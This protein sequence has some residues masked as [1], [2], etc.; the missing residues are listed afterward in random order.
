MPKNSDYW[1]DRATSRMENYHRQTEYNKAIRQAYGEAIRNIQRDIDRILRNLSRR[2]G[3]TQEEIESELEKPVDINIIKEYKD[4][5]LSATDDGA[6]KRMQETLNIA[7][8][9]ARM[10]RL[11]AIETAI[12]LELQKAA[13]TQIQADRIVLGKIIDDAYYR[14]MFHIQKGVGYGFSFNPLSKSAANEILR[15]LWSGKSWSSR[16][17]TNTNILADRLPKS[18]MASFL[19]GI[20][21]TDLVREFQEQAKTQIMTQATYFARRLVYTE[22]T[23]VANMTEIESY[24]ECDVLDYIFLA[25]LDLVTSEICRDLD[26]KEFPV[27]EAAPGVN[28]APMHPF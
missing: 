23:Y 14:T 3:L 8:S 19:S 26:G 28:L 10:T 1:Q 7:S 17:W 15:N 4:K 21:P 22:I 24:N 11:E 27:A 12:K 6:K 20:N 16:V 5:L 25:T 18:I 13:E 9:K 2:T